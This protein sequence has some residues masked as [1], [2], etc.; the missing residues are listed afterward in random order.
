MTLASCFFRCYSACRLIV[1]AADEVYATIIRQL[2]PSST[3]K[4]MLLD[5]EDRVLNM[6]SS[7]SA[8]LGIESLSGVGVERDEWYASRGETI[9]ASQHGLT[10]R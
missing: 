9:D 6:M 5:V 7:G 2:R 4:A 1:V 3:C 10:L 8:E